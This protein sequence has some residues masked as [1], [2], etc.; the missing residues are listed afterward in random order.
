MARSVDYAHLDVDLFTHPK[1]I[2]L[3]EDGGTDAFTAWIALICWARSKVDPEHLDRA[4]VI[5]VAVA[6]HVIGGLGLGLDPRVM[7]ETLEKHGLLDPHLT[8]GRWSLHDFVDQQKLREWASRQAR[9]IK[10]GQARGAQLR[11]NGQ[12]HGSLGSTLSVS[13]SDLKNPSSNEAF[14]AFW[15]VYPRKVGKIEA[16]RKWDTAVRLAAPGA[17]I[18]GAVRYAKQRDG[19]DITLTAHPATWLHQ[20]RWADEEET[21]QQTKANRETSAYNRIA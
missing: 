7:V 4:G 5:T 19:Q 20:G 1:I 10:G 14:D 13:V 21:P 3:L 9:N 16:R 2:E 8:P 6:R 15:K 17:I 18:D 12:P 11:A